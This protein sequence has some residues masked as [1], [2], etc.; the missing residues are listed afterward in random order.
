MQP[1]E[2]RIP[3]GERAGLDLKRYMLDVQPNGQATPVFFPFSSFSGH[4]LRNCGRLS[5]CD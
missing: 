5:T 3:G 2:V 1:I 4:Y